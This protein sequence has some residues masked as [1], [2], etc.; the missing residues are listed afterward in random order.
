MLP[1]GQAQI[2]AAAGSPSA[3]ILPGLQPRKGNTGFPASASRA[4]TALTSD[5]SAYAD[6]PRGEFTKVNSP[7]PGPSGACLATTGVKRRAI[8][9]LMRQ[10]QFEFERC[11]PA[12]PSN[13]TPCSRD[14]GTHPEAKSAHAVSPMGS[15]LAA[16]AAM[17][18][19]DDPPSGGSS[20]LSHGNII[21]KREFRERDLRISRGSMRDLRKGDERSI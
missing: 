2:C 7:L 8:R 11:A 12:H 3:F 21:I 4:L 6:A 9:E 17:S 1:S 15:R 18:E 5:A 13:F 16:P 14:S 20:N 10:H 19:I